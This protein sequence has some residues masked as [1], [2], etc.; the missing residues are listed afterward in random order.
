MH[1]RELLVLLAATFITACTEQDTSQAVFDA[2]VDRPAVATVNGTQISQDV[3]DLFISQRANA[4]RAELNDEQLAE[5]VNQVIN[6]ELLAQDAVNNNLHA[7]SQVA[8]Q[9]QLDRME[10]LAAASI[11]VYFET[12]PITEEMLQAE[13]QRSLAE[14]DGLEYNARHILVD[15]E[16]QAIDLIDQLNGGAD[17]DALARRSSIEPGAEQRAGDLGWFTTGQMVKPFS[18]AVKAMN[19]GEVSKEPV[20]TQFGWHVIELRETRDAPMPTFEDLRQR[21]EF[22]VKNGQIEGYVNMLRGA[23]DILRVDKG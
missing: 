4:N 13:Y 17:F 12:H 9:L 18:D 15:T 16:Q 8:D 3:I 1:K 22:Q 7:D 20:Q 23:A 21:L 2:P 19:V 5:L 10:T 11:R 14:I 6:F